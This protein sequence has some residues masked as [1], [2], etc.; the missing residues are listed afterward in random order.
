MVS[1]QIDRVCR[2]DRKN[3]LAN[4]VSETKSE[5]RVELH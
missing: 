3:L 4:A 5:G 2:I 1:E